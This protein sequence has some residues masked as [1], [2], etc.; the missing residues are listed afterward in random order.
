MQ[1]LFDSYTRGRD[2]LDPQG[3]LDMLMDMLP[4]LTKG[5]LYYFQV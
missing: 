3:L 1:E 5:D 4:N 2:Y